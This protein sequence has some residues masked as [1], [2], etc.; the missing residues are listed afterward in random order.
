[1]VLEMSYLAATSRAD[2]LGPR[3]R[4]VLQMIALGQSDEQVAEQLEL[5]PDVAAKLCGDVFDTLGIHPTAYLSRR[6]LAALTLR[7]RA[8]GGPEA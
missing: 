8:R 5:A 2:R 3:E 1:M 7:A 4:E 6:T